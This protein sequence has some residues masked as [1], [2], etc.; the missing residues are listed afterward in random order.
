M[1]PLHA[2]AVFFVCLVVTFTVGGIVLAI[3]DWYGRRRS[4]RRALRE[5]ESLF[6]AKRGM[7]R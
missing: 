6:V 2:A 5:V 1:T 7:P 3:S 4:R